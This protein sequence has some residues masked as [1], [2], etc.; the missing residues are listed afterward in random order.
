M[1]WKQTAIF[2][3]VIFPILF[4][5]SLE[6]HSLLCNFSL[7]SHNCHPG[8]NLLYSSLTTKLLQVEWDKTDWSFFFRIKAANVNMVLKKKVWFKICLLFWM[9]S[10][11]NQYVNIPIL[12]MVLTWHKFK[13]EFRFIKLSHKHQKYQVLNKWHIYFFCFCP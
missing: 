13:A 3:P 9:S 6:S 5:C 10:K 8:H 7:H 12:N 1:P 11:C 2:S 4:V